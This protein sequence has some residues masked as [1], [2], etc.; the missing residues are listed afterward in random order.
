MK[1]FNKKAL[2]LGSLAL[3]LTLGLFG[4]GKKPI[5]VV[6][7]NVN[8]SQNANIATSTN[9]IYSIPEL[10]LRLAFPEINCKDFTNYNL[11]LSELN[12]YCTKYFGGNII[13]KDN[14]I[15]E[16]EKSNDNFFVKYD[17]QYLTELFSNDDKEIIKKS[18]DLYNDFIKKEKSQYKISIFLND[19][20]SKKEIARWY[21]T[22]NIENITEKE[23]LYWNVCEAGCSVYLKKI[24]GDYIIWQ[25]G[26]N[27]SSGAGDM[28]LKVSVPH[29]KYAG[30]EQKKCE[31]VAIIDR[32]IGKKVKFI[33]E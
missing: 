19:Q 30:D 11:P 24:I 7:A 20:L 16:T 12:E 18:V 1:K 4:C 9:I 13:K 27:P 2:V 3:I 15:F 21:V 23:L 26:I 31:I 28:C 33:L 32:F 25:I 6:N 29:E 17:Y 5:S 10:K 14:L 22:K 8:Q